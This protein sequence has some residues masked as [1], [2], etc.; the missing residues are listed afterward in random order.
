MEIVCPAVMPV[1]VKVP[2]PVANAAA[3]DV[4]KSTFA[5]LVIVAVWPFT[6]ATAVTVP[7]AVAAIEAVA[8]T[9]SVFAPFVIV[10][11][12]PFVGPVDVTVPLSVA[13]TAVLEPTTSTGYTTK[14]LHIA[15]VVLNEYFAGKSKPPSGAEENAVL[16]NS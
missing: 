4:I 3:V 8:I 13:N 16:A 14:S 10:A 6:G 1:V 9:V 7:L 15:V 11:V 12:W 2:E 5:P